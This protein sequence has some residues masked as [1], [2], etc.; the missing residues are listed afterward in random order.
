MRYYFSS[1]RI[2]YNRRNDQR[3]YITLPISIFFAN[4][5]YIKNLWGIILKE[6]SLCESCFGKGNGVK[7]VSRGN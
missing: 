4:E 3:I 2:L 1:Y 6:I 7:D 5:V